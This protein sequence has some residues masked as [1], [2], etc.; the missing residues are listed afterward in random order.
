V[1]QGVWPRLRRSRGRVFVV[2]ITHVAICC[3]KLDGISDLTYARSAFVGG[4]FP[5]CID[6]KL[7][8]VLSSN[9]ICVAKP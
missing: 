9:Y 6:R 5:E 2:S 7:K 8:D 1:Q 4:R 3:E